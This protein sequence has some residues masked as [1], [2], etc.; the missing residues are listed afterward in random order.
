V[1]D[2]ADDIAR[3][4]ARTKLDQLRQVQSILNL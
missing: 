4:K 2:A 1:A 3:D